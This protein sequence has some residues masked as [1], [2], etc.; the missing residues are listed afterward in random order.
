MV[1]EEEVVYVIG[2]Y[3]QLLTNANTV[4]MRT[5]DWFRDSYRVIVLK[6]LSNV[7][8]RSLILCTCELIDSI[9]EDEERDSTLRIL[10]PFDCLTDDY[11]GN[12]KVVD[13]GRLIIL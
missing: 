9:G 1:S 5:F 4:L 10:I 6:A 7:D 12:N 2:L 11:L 8:D 3:E 13:S